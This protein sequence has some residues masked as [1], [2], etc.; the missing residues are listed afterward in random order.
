MAS[1]VQEKWRSST[2]ALPRA[3]GPP[4]S[5][6]SRSSSTPSLVVQP[7]S[8]YACVLRA[9]EELVGCDGAA[10]LLL[11]PDLNL[12]QPVAAR[13]LTQDSLAGVR[14]RSSDNL[15]TWLKVNEIPL[16][17][18]SQS[19]LALENA[20]LYRQQSERL[21]RM[22]RAERLATTG[23]LASGVAH[24]IRNPLTA[25]RSTIQLLARDF[26]GDAARRELL[27][28]VLAEVDR[29]NQIITQ[30]LSFARPAEFRVAPV[31]LNALIEASLSLVAA[32]ARLGNV[33]IARELREL[34]SVPGDESQLKQLFLNLFMNAFEAMPR[35]G[36]LRVE[37]AC[38]VGILACGPITRDFVRVAIADTGG[39]MSEEVLERIFDPFFTTKPEGTGKELVARAIHESSARA[40]GP[41]LSVN[42]GAIPATLFESE[43]FGFERGAFTDARRGRVAGR[44]PQDAVQQDAAVRSVGRR[45]SGR[46]TAGIRPPRREVAPRSSRPVWPRTSEPLPCRLPP[47]CRAA[48]PERLVLARGI[49]P[50]GLQQAHLGAQVRGKEAGVGP[51]SE[52]VQVA[53]E[54]EV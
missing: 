40:Q 30:L 31:E 49:L 19:A 8:L 29:I 11:D 51:V 32:Q 25:I 16:A 35:G 23:Q 28:G 18:A 36:E 4:A 2:R 52:G 53:I 12:F 48:G 1:I 3:A 10:L 34:P 47:A 15:I 5:G 33:R 50:I 17:V 43:F 7:E 6:H 41:F 54:T 22:H 24:E 27:E 20:L 13:G 14:F 9:L 26:Q 39:G 46:R 21:R 37:S 38:S 42:C 45:L 44:Q